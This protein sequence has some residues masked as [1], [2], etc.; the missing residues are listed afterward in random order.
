MTITRTKVKQ[1][2]EEHGI[3]LD[4][5]E[6]RCGYSN[7]G[8]PGIN[9]VH[10]YAKPGEVFGTND[11]HSMSLWYCECVEP[12]NW[13]EVLAN[14]CDHMPVACPFMLANGGTGCEVCEGYEA[15]LMVFTDFA[16]S[17]TYGEE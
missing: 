1:F 15:N 11:L 14:L 2:A 16:A 3:E 12:I 13:M 4:I 8:R 5:V 7:H 17:A 10:A 6:F 9:H